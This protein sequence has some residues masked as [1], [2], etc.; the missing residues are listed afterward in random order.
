MYDQDQEYV[1]FTQEQ[2]PKYDK[3]TGRNVDSTAEDE[4]MEEE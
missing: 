3:Q 2:E 4:E 1:D